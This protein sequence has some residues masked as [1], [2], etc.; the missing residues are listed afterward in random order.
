MLDNYN[1]LG[2]FVIFIFF[3]AGTIYLGIKYFNSLETFVPLVNEITLGKRNYSIYQDKICVG[4]A[5]VEFNRPNEELWTLV[6]SGK[7][8][9]EKVGKVSLDWE[10]SF[11]SIGQLGA[12]LFS[13]NIADLSFKGGTL[14][15]KPIRVILRE[16]RNF[17]ISHP[18]PILLQKRGEVYSLALPIKKSFKTQKSP[19]KIIQTDCI[20]KGEAKLLDVTVPQIFKE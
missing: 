3:L 9:V 15:V 11:N 10:L 7:V 17:E 18:G 5:S 1:K 8:N 6:M 16:P 12:S 2:K 4:E 19:F 13:G 14:G 20:N